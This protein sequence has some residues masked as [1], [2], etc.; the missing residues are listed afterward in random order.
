M[1][2]NTN[3][4]FHIIFL[5]PLKLGPLV[6]S[7]TNATLQ[8]LY[9]VVTL[10]KQEYILFKIWEDTHLCSG[11]LASRPKNTEPTIAKKRVGHSKKRV[12][13]TA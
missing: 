9:T 6:R 1:Q 5:W 3:T 8:L 12:D 13:S 10:T 2:L 4:K 11:Y 7:S